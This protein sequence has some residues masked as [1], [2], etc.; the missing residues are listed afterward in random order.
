M[1]G[2]SH[3][4]QCDIREGIGVLTPRHCAAAPSPCNP[5][6]YCPS[7]PLPP[8]G[9]GKLYATFLPADDPTKMA[10]GSTPRGVSILARDLQAREAGCSCL[11]VPAIWGLAPLAAVRPASPA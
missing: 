10:P 3:G 6:S 11:L 7:L 4:L 8:G 2:G 5:T 9:D 1:E